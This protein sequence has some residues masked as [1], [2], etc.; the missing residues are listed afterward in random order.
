MRKLIKIGIFIIV[1][2]LISY[3]VYEFVTVA[4]ISRG[5]RNNMV[6]DDLAQ[7]YLGIGILFIPL[8]VYPTIL[9]LSLILNYIF[10]IKI[11]N[12]YIIQICVVFN[13]WMKIYR[14]FIDYNY[15]IYYFNE[16]FNLWDYHISILI[17]LFLWGAYL[18]LT[19]SNELAKKETKK[20][21]LGG[22]T[23]ISLVCGLPIYFGYGILT[24][25]I[26]LFYIYVSIFFGASVLL[27]KCVKTNKTKLFDKRITIELSIFL[28]V[29]SIMV[30][31]FPV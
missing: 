3:S 19:N 30:S 12:N 13:F 1:L 6:S 29:G 21:T 28:A 25:N 16:Y 11:L 14:I 10:K 27:T 9:I 4:N 20:K 24:F 23:F 26:W 5:Y 31:L 7:G 2:F 18:Y 17:F 15:K 22:I 8:I